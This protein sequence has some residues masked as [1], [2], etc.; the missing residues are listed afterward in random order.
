MI[1]CLYC[2]A[3]NAADHKFCKNCGKPLS[4]PSAPEETIIIRLL[5]ASIG[6]TPHTRLARL[7]LLDFSGEKVEENYELSN[8]KVIIGRREDCSIPLSGST[9]SRRHAMIRHS[10]G[11]FYISDL[12][13]TNGTM[14]NS[15]MLVGEEELHDRDEIGVGI[16]KL[17]FRY[18]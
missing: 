3:E 9:V 17:I 18:A 7:W 15:E 1:K 13:S 10:D 11:I 6:A 4:A 12:G 16:Y 8:E 2:A 5:D 14:L